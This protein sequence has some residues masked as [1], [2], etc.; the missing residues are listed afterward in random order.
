MQLC[1]TICSI[2]H[3][4]SSINTV[5]YSS[6]LL[7]HLHSASHC[8]GYTLRCCSRLTSQY[9]LILPLQRAR[10]LVGVCRL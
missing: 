6:H 2:A 9:T 8:R 1:N 3:N 4:T 7:T 10:T 5:V